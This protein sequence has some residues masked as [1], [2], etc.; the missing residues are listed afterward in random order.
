M[1]VLSQ[2]LLVEVVLSFAFLSAIIFLVV[3]RKDR[4]LSRETYE[5]L[6]ARKWPI[7]ALVI[8]Y[9]TTLFL[10]IVHELLE[11]IPTF[12]PISPRQTDYLF[13][14]HV[15]IYMPLVPFLGVVL[16]LFVKAM[17]RPQ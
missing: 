1:P 14:R 12:Y 8:I 13:I 16:F 5:R 15:I 9:F 2:L 6:V 10:F 7:R 4:F 11:L 3:A 17:R